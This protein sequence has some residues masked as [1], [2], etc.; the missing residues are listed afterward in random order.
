[1]STLSIGLLLPEVLGTYGDDGN[2]RVLQ[3]RA[4]QRGI[5]AQILPINLG[6]G[7][8]ELLDIY[9]IGGGEDT[10]QII[11]CEYLQQHPGLYRAAENGTPIL[12]ICAG[13][14]IL[15]QQFRAAGRMVDGLGLLDITT[16]TMAAR[17]IGEVVTTPTGV[18][19][20]AELT[21]ALTGFENH[22]GAT[23]LGENAKPLGTLARGVGNTDQQAAA[24]TSDPAFQVSAE[25]VVQ[26][27]IIATY[28]H[29]PALAR[30]PQLADLL[31]A[32]ATG[33]PLRSLA[34]CPG[35][36]RIAQLRSER[37]AAK[38]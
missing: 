17:A 38:A 27:S 18:G 7:V 9:L 34:P 36:E 8:P 21:E 10:A 22:M 25:G 26:G 2:A 15:G 12:S 3:V 5:D 4:K 6:D 20:T 1:M 24:T 11:A 29:G 32:N 13:M 16:G 33:V 31:L 19:V 30:N 37:L 35:D 28:M 14:Q 23:L